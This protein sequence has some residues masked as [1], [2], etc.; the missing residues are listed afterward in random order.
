MIKERK[1][2]QSLKTIS[3]I[4]SSSKKEN[5]NEQLV[6]LCT[7]IRSL[8]LD[9]NNNGSSS[10]IKVEYKCFVCLV[11]NNDNSFPPSSFDIKHSLTHSL[12]NNCHS[13]IAEEK[14]RISVKWYQLYYSIRSP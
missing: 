12:D 9:N 4:S 2:N 14:E 5:N 6:L 3:P 13:I 10:S 8:S 1:E 11:V 7:K